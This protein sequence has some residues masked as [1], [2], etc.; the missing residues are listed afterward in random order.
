MEQKLEIKTRV[1]RRGN[2]EVFLVDGHI[3]VRCING[4]FLMDCEDLPIYEKSCWKINKCG[5]GYVMSG[6]KNNKNNDFHGEYYLLH[7]AVMKA[8]KGQSVDHINRDKLDN[9]KSNLRICSHRENM[10]NSKKRSFTSSKY[11]GVCFRKNRKSPF[12]AYL[13]KD[14]KRKCLGYF[15]TEAEAALAYNKEAKKSFGEFARLNE[16]PNE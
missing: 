8:N 16:V 15:K 5:A 1:K 13:D 11:K 3:E 10:R 7:R 9:R 4:T 12:F 2:Q 6:K 14:K